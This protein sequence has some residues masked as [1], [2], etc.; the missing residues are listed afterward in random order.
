M[1]RISQGSGRGVRV[2]FRGR[3]A[4][5]DGDSAGHSLPL[6]DEDLDSRPVTND[7]F[8]RR[9]ELDHAESGGA[10]D[11]I[12]RNQWADDS[13]SDGPR[14]LSDAD[15]LAAIRFEDDQI[16]FIDL[17]GFLGAGIEISA[18]SMRDRDDFRIAGGAVDVNIE[19]AQEDSNQY[20][21]FAV[22]RF[23]A[24]ESFDQTDLSVRG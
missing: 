14:D 16:R 18:R 6:R 15:R 5:Q 2:R 24:V 11:S 13:S 19:H 21:G 22:G 12:P 17:G 7:Q 3:L 10:G 20:C 8:R 9:T 1:L 4:N 23:M